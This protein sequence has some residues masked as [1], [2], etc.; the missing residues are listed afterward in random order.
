MPFHASVACSQGCPLQRIEACISYS[1]LSVLQD[2]WVLESYPHLGCNEGR[3]YHR[4]PAFQLIME[5]LERLEGVKR[6]SCVANIA[7]SSVQSPALIS[8]RQ[9]CGWKMALCTS[10]SILKAQGLASTE[11]LRRHHG[12]GHRLCFIARMLKV[13]QASICSHTCSRHLP[14]RGSHTDT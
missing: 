14:G 2:I 8:V 13:L 3:A 7:G 11:A 9:E 6:L 5:T 4:T 12:R 10:A 1:S